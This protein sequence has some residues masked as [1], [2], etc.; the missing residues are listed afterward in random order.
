M[1]E[2]VCFGV[3]SGLSFLKYCRI[4]SQSP[5]FLS[6]LENRPFNGGGIYYIL[7]KKT[8]ELVRSCSEKITTTKVHI[9]E[10]YT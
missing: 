6:N 4:L 7:P 3:V 9:I 8:D 10:V 5:I 2:Q 1:L